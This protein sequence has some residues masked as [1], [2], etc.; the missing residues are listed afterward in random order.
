MRLLIYYKPNIDKFVI[1]YNQD[2]QHSLP[3]DSVNCYGHII[4]QY[5]YIEDNR[6]FYSYSK[7]DKYLDHKYRNRKPSLRYRLG[8]RIIK[9]GNV[10]C[11]GKDK[12]KVIY[13]DRYKYPWWK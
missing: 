13:I 12:V 9:F 6:V 2:R 4:I 11:F 5:W 8:Q 1:N 10:V 3:I 7:Y